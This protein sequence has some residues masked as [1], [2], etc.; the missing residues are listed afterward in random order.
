MID[1]VR[2]TSLPP[3][4]ATREPDCEHDRGQPASLCRECRRTR[5][6]PWQTAWEAYNRAAVAS[7]TCELR[8]FGNEPA[9]SPFVPMER[10]YP[11]QKWCVTH[12]CVH[13]PASGKG[14]SDV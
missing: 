9:G 10:L 1:N 3:R 7:G 2:M 4:P 5:F 13:V 8:D 6:L 14:R 11:G 12:R